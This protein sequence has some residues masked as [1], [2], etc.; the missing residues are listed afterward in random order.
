MNPSLTV[1]QHAPE[2]QPQQGRHLEGQQ[3]P[4]GQAGRHLHHLHHPDQSHHLHQLQGE[5]EQ[6][7]EAEHPQK[8]WVGHHPFQLLARWI[9]AGH[10]ALRC[11]GEGRQ[12]PAAGEG[13]HRGDRAGDAPHHQIAIGPLAEHHRGDDQAAEAREDRAGEAGGVQAGPQGRDR[14]QL[15]GE[16]RVGQVHAGVGAHQQDRHH[17]VVPGALPEAPGGDPPHRRQADAE[18]QCCAQHPGQPRAPAAVGVVAQPADQRIIEGIPHLDHGEQRARD[19]G[20]QAGGA[21]EEREEVEAEL[22]GGQSGAGIAE[23]VGD[24]QPAA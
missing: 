12:T 2:L 3:Q 7:V 18:G 11:L 21:G 17:H 6:Q 9:A 22:G 10:G 8:A 5:P 20:G 1:A 16:G 13:G 15:R 19:E 23:A 4:G 14:R 24:H